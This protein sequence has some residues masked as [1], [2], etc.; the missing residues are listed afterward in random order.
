MAKYPVVQ[1]TIIA[2]LIVWSLEKVFIQMLKACMLIW[3]QD[4]FFFFFTL[5]SLLPLE[6]GF[7]KVRSFILLGVW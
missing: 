4:L 7:T 6:G 5:S 1:L 3:A 2:I